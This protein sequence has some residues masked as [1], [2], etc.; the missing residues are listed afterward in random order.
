MK[1]NKNANI[2]H[3]IGIGGIGMSA[4]ARYFLSQNWQVSG[5]DASASFIT[6]NLKR[7]GARVY[8]G[9][10]TSNLP[11]KTDL[12]VYSAAVLPEDNQELI[13]EKKTGT[14]T[15]TYAETIGELTKKYKTI[16]IAGAPGKSTTTALLSLVFIKAGL[17]PTIIIG[18]NLKEFG[19]R[20][21]KRG[22]SSY[23]ILEADEYQKS[24]L[25]YSPFAAIIT[26]I[27][28]E[29]LDVY[30]NL[31]N[32]KKV[33]LKFIGNIQPN[34]FLIVNKDDKNLFSLKNKIQKI[35]DKNKL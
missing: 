19:N 21:F 14:A 15:Q 32:I 4:L 7:E 13:K 10:R 26:N 29:H 12:V 31:S 34:G 30:K 6:Q 24:F 27:D 25:N 5:S 11:S 16:T 17:D 18:T 20:N 3:F 35:A 23:L 28:R 1:I 9:H 33:F 22:N 8:V 2:I